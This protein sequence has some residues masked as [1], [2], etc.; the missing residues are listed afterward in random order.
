[1]KNIIKFLFLLLSFNILSQGTISYT[2]GTSNYNSLPI[3]GLYDYS[4]SG[5]ILLQ[6]EIGVG[7]KEINNIQVQLGGYTTPYTF[8]NQDIYLAHVTESEF[9]SSPNV[10]LSDLTISNLTKCV[11]GQNLTISSNGWVTL[12]FDANF[13]YNG[14]DNIVILWESHDGSWSSGYGYAETSTTYTNRSFEKHQDG[15]FPTGTGTR[16]SRLINVQ[17]DWAVPSALPIILTNFNGYNENNSNFLTFGLINTNLVNK[18][19]ITRSIDGVEWNLI[20]VCSEC[21]NYNNIT[22]EDR[23]YDYEINYYKIEIIG[24]NNTI[25]D[26][27]I[28]SIDNREN[29]EYKIII[30]DILGRKTNNIKGNKIIINSNGE[31]QNSYN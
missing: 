29:S 6:S 7:T 13:S 28:I 3:Y 8:N 11:N 15:S 14:T 19:T 21:S 24:I 4:V 5:F 26:S 27:D 9:D 12:T 16:N 18:T 31:I 20:Y 2:S 1:M 10:D 30:Y 22:L 17:L 25:L 23:D